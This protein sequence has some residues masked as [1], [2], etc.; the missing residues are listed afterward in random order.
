MSDPIWKKRVTIEELVRRHEN[1]L[2]AHLGIEFLEIGP[3]SLRARMPVDARTVQPMGIV[4]GGASV[5]LAETIG[6]VAW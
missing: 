6:S 1:T 5:A 2:V 3:D 4:H